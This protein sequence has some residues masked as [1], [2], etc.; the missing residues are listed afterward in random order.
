M[1][2]FSYSTKESKEEIGCV[3]VHCSTLLSVIFFLVS[4]IEKSTS[5]ILSSAEMAESGKEE[6][7]GVKDTLTETEN[8][9]Y[10]VTNGDT[11]IIDMEYANKELEAARKAHKRLTEEK[12]ALTEALNSRRAKIQVQL[13]Y[14]SILTLFS[15]VCKP[16]LY[17]FENNSCLFL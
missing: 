17:A 9:D 13:N 2:E 6:L 8:A 12:I 10:L 4:R 15:R 14:K 16:Y 5:L 1:T 11:P 7:H 3:P